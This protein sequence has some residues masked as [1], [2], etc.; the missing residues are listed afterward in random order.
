M[1]KNRQKNFDASNLVFYLKIIGPGNIK[2]TQAGSTKAGQ[3]YRSLEGFYLHENTS[4]VLQNNNRLTRVG[5]ADLYKD[6][7]MTTDIKRMIE[8]VKLDNTEIGLQ[9]RSKVR[10]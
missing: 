8:G 3:N 6:C 2:S 5:T 7:E 9:E 10:E 1:A 4:D